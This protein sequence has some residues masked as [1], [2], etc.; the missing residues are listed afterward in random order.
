MDETDYRI[1]QILKG[2][3]RTPF[4][5]IAKRLDAS[6]GTIRLRVKKMVDEGVIKQFTIDTSGSGIKALIDV[7]L[8]TNYDT[9]EVAKKIGR[10]DGVKVV[11]EVTGEDDVVVLADVKGTDELNDLVEAIRRMDVISTKTRLIMKEH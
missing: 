1:L 10:L 5:N 6:E 3:A 4:V 2:D 11:Y 8:Q 7:R 9:S